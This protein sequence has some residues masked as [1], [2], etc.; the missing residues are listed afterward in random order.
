MYCFVSFFLALLNFYLIILFD[1]DL[2]PSATIVLILTFV[3]LCFILTSFIE[4][5]FFL[6][7]FF[8]WSNR[9]CD[10]TVKNLLRTCIFLQ[11][12]QYGSSSRRIH[13]TKPA[14]DLSSGIIFFSKSSCVQST[15][16]TWAYVLVL[17]F[18]FSIV[19]SQ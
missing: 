14:V 8:S 1:L 7:L 3:Q 6:H 11:L 10:S 4:L 9:F 12:I 13:R 2:V 16:N 5:V 17:I 15:H 18:S 19:L